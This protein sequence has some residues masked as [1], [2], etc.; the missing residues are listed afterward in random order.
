MANA[1]D[2]ELRHLRYFVALAEEQ[3]FER[4]AARLGIAQPGLSQQIIKLEA[5]LGVSLLDRSR[6]SLR[7]TGPG[8][9]FV[10]QARRV[11]GTL[12]DAIEAVHRAARGDLERV[13][14]GYV[15][16]AA[17]SGVL[18]EALSKFKASK[19]SIDFHLIEMEMRLQ[20]EKISDKTLDVG[21]IRPPIA[22]P[23]GLSAEVAVR[24]DFVVALPVGHKYAAVSS[25]PLK[26]LS[27]EIFIT[28]RQPPDVGFH[29]NTLAACKEAG[30][31][32][33]INSSGRDFTTIASMVVLGVGVALVPRSF[34][35][36]RLPGISYTK[37]KG[38][39]VTSDLAIAYRKVE[40]SP[41]IKSF[42]AHFKRTL[43]SEQESFE[44]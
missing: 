6:R 36:V 10:E 37:L 34:Q 14:V 9:E 39:S 7:L 20:L 23:S 25:I 41:T 29:R 21:F 17:Y 30:F 44:G 8:L 32:P 33:N 24:E 22:L 1:S 43:P 18:V 11:I 35:C 4:A 27:S 40:P 2:I 3:N 13:S 42:I 38:C 5:L 26:A 16:S 15:A 28:P 19:P 31:Q 12:Q